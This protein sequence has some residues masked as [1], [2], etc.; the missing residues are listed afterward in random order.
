MKKYFV[1]FFV[2]ISFFSTSYSQ[3]LKDYINIGG[4]YNSA[5]HSGDLLYE[6]SYGGTAQFETE[7]SDDLTLV[8]SVG[9]FD[10]GS[11]SFVDDSTGED[12]STDLYSIPV[13][14]GLKYY[15]FEAL[16]LYATLQLGVDMSFLTI[17]GTDDAGE[18]PEEF[19]TIRLGAGYEIPI[20]E[21]IKIDLT[22]MY[23]IID[24]YNYLT[25]R[26]GVKVALD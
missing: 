10:W 21:K 13:M 24:E 9:Y 18:Y 3:T 5:L 12:Y 20:T 2:V 16:D 19:I 4:E 11:R 15:I 14:G 22:G 26:A 7:L 23:Y 1:L 8:L 25:G 17:H 6:N